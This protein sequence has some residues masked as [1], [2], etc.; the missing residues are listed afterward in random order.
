MIL[1][2]KHKG[3]RKLYEEDSPKGV[4]RQYAEKIRRMLF[5]L[6]DAVSPQDLDLPGYRLHALT[7]NL[8][9]YFSMVVGANWRIIFR[10]E[11]AHVTD[12][13]MVDYH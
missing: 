3:L 10:F 5:K 7:G 9:G 11:G 8:K 4:Q 12:V 13:D 6:E 2:I 1:H